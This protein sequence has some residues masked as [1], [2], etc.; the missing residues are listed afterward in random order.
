MVKSV[1]P[2]YGF[3]GAETERFSEDINMSMKKSCKKDM[4]LRVKN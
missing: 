4:P 3:P 1:V 2:D